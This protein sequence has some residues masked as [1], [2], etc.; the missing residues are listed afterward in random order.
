MPTIKISAD[1]HA[2]ATLAAGAA[3]QSLPAY[4]ETALKEALERDR[5]QHRERQYHAAV[6]KAEQDL[7]PVPLRSEF[8][9][10]GA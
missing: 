10:K 1:T 5:Q 6:K 2:R 8:F 7:K 3:G 9:K 4:A